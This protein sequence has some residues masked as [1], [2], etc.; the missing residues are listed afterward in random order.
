MCFSVFLY[1]FQSLLLLA[2]STTMSHLQRRFGLR[3]LLLDA[4]TVWLCQPRTSCGRGVAAASLALSP[5]PSLCV[6]HRRSVCV[7]NFINHISKTTKWFSPD[8]DVKILSF[9]SW[10]QV[11]HLAGRHVIQVCCS[12]DA[13]INVLFFSKIKFTHL[14]YVI[15]NHRLCAVPTTA[16]PWFAVCPQIVTTARNLP[17]KQ[18][19]ATHHSI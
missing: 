2:W 14:Y 13:L 3:I 1:Q 17:K 10:L 19:V 7:I 4:S 11:E 5:P 16:W 8:L 12:S 18:S 6:D 9:L 15:F